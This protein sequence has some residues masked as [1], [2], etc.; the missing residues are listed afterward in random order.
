M[1]DAK[2]YSMSLTWRLVL[3]FTLG[4]IVTMT[5]AS[6]YLRHSMRVHLEKQDY[7]VLADHVLALEQAL[8]KHA[9]DPKPAYEHLIQSCDDRKIHRICGRIFDQD[10]TLL[11]TSQGMTAMGPPEAAFPKPPASTQAPVIVRHAGPDENLMVVF[12]LSARITNG[13]NS[14]LYQAMYASNHVEQAMA[15]YNRSLI[16]TT[17][18]T[19]LIAALLG[20]VLAHNGLRP[21]RTIAKT[22]KRVT[23]SDLNE[24]LSTQ[25]WPKE[26]SSLAHEFDRMLQRLQQSFNHLSQ[27]TADAAHEFRTP[28]NNLMG[29]TSLALSKDRTPEQYQRLLQ[30]HI[31]QYERL[32][33]MVESLLFL[34]RADN[35]GAGFRLVQIDAAACAKAVLEFYAAVAEERGI[36]L[37]LSGNAIV[38]ADES[39]LRI[40]L[41]NLVSNG[42][43]YTPSGGLLQI[44]IAAH[45]SNGTMISVTDS[46]P[47][48]APEHFAHIFDRYYRVEK[49]RSTGGAGLGLSLVQT[50]M[51]LHGGCAQVTSEPRQGATFSLVFPAS[52]QV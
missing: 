9:L 29:A 18:S 44:H 20:W 23:A 49:S 13:E 8:D 38:L 14:Y 28:L 4:C 27:F 50:I 35:S 41:S 19:S 3:C 21:L 12:L 11:F 43:R 33:R 15:H 51:R 22:M 1:P 39:M 2:K 52:E 30:E 25:D 24:R 36:R 6:L 32:N 45:D 40:A 7:E 48:I 17:I 42:L 16:I 37:Q 46:G 10:G 47:G 5:C 34:A 31:E 26:L